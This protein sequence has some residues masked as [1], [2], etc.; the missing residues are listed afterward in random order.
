MTTGD[1]KITREDIEAKVTE[2]EAV[3]QGGVERAK[4]QLLATGIFVSLLIIAIAYLFGRKLGA[5]RSTIVEV[6]RI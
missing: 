4:P 1:G 6:T 5:K 3:L 2:I